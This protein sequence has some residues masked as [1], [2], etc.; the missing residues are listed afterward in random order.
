MIYEALKK[1]N[2]LNIE[3]FSSFSKDFVKNIYEDNII[4]FIN[5]LL[6]VL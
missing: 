4:V 6:L 2:N 5:L 3:I 1:K